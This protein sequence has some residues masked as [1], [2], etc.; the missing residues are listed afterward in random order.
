MKL[1]L[2]P[3]ASTNVVSAGNN[4]SLKSVVHG[5]ESF[6]STCWTL[7]GSKHSLLFSKNLQAYYRKIWCMTFDALAFGEIMPSNFS[8]STSLINFG[9]FENF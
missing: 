1:G 6:S 8:N 2:L 5:S 7:Q 4:Q 3:V 9:P